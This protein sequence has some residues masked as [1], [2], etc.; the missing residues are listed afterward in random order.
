[1]PALIT[2]TM[3][4]DGNWPTTLRHAIATAEALPGPDVIQ[5]GAGAFDANGNCVVDLLA[6]LPTL[7]QPLQI[8]GGVVPGMN[9]PVIQPGPAARVGQPPPYRV[10]NVDIPLAQK[11]APVL[12][13]YVEI[14][15]G[16]TPNFPD[17]NGGGIKSVNAD[18]TIENCRVLSNHA[19]GDGGG[20]WATGAQCMLWVKGTTTMV[21]GNLAVG[22]GGGIAVENIYTLIDDGAKVELNRAMVSGGGIAAFAD[23]FLP[24][25]GAAGNRLL[26]FN[27]SV[28]AVSVSVNTAHNG[29]GGGVFVKHIAGLVPDVEFDTATVSQNK[30]YGTP[31]VAGAWTSGRGGGVAVLGTATVNANAAT[32]VSDNGQS[33]PVVAPAVLGVHFDIAVGGTFAGT[34]TIQNNFLLP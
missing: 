29:D 17:W 23:N 10:F 34:A 33:A 22:S 24:R 4:G 12:F 16:H 28:N 11:G 31:P 20:I 2:V 9:R 1:V 15:G 32:L 5:F 27:G 30:A 21:G 3:P 18:L 25:G 8:L 26:D 7:T 6:P 19:Y 13:N 14:K